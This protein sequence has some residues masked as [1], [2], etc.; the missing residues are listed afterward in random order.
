MN[1]DNPQKPEDCETQNQ[2]SADTRIRNLIT[3]L[4]DPM[5]LLSIERVIREQNKGTQI[6]EDGYILKRK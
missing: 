5:M 3:N 6:T 2:S 4:N 1:A